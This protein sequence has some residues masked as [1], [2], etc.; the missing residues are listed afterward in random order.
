MENAI[1]YMFLGTIAIMVIMDKVISY[2]QRGILSIR[3]LSEQNAGQKY[4]YQ[5]LFELRSCK[6]VELILYSDQLYK[7]ISA[8]FFTR[9]MEKHREYYRFKY[10]D[11]TYTI[12]KEEVEAVEF[13]RSWNIGWWQEE[14]WLLRCDNSS[15]DCMAVGKETI[16]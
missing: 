7:S 16:K 5:I 6:D 1:Y 8:V 12:P 4:K 13:A 15:C 3:G 11:K 14:S 2:Y 9:F 10:Q